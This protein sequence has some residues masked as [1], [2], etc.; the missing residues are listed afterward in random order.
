MRHLKKFLAAILVTLLAAMLLATIY[1][2]LFDLQWIAFLGGVLFA[3]IAALSTQTAKAQWLV[4]RRTRQMERGKSLLAA[5]IAR[6]LMVDDELAVGQARLQLIIDALP[7]MIVF[8]DRDE[9]CGHHN[10]AFQNWCGRSRDRINGFTLREVGGDAVYQD[11][12]SHSTDA[13]GGRQIQYDTAWQSQDSDEQTMAVTLVPY[14]PGIERTTGFYALIIPTVAA[15]S[16]PAEKNVT[17]LSPVIPA[18]SHG[19]SVY[20]Q[21]MTEQLLGGGDPRRELMRALEQDEFIL[22]AQEIRALGPEADGHCV[23]VLLRL[24]EEEQNMLPPGGFFPAAERYD[25]MAEID[26][27]VVRN[28]LKWSATVQ[29]TDPAWRM[30]LCCIN[31]SNAS[32]RNARFG[33]YVQGELERCNI[34]GSSLCFEIAEGDLIRHHGEVQAL[35]GLLRPLGCRFTVDG[36]GGVRVSFAPFSDLTFD[37]LKIDGSIIQNILHEPSEL[38]KTKAIVLACRDIGVRTI[39]GLVESDETL[40]KLREIGVDYVQGFNISRPAPLA[41]AG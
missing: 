6:R 25:L 22:F 12:K 19:E 9:R 31:I 1:F 17:A 40:A 16:S 36:F 37:F 14:P 11:I 18:Q 26:R 21:S 29:Q 24:Q 4:A 20:L 30:P 23:E 35:I 28:V 34:A 8:I 41:D 39:A 7:D 38:A 10:R 32:L 27:W 15:V 13:L 3:A 33:R 5:E 2:T